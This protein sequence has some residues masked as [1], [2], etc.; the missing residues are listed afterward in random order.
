MPHSGETYDT[1]APITGD[2]DAEDEFLEWLDNAVAAIRGEN[3]TQGEHVDHVAQPEWVEASG[4]PVVTID[5]TGRSIHQR[6]LPPGQPVRIKVP[7][8]TVYLFPAQRNE[9]PEDS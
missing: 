8:S 3:P 9:E 2:P 5:L 7:G 1:D 4:L 6:D